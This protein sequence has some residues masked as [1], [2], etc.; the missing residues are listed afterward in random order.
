M[1]FLGFGSVLT[2]FP[3]RPVDLKETNTNGAGLTT[4]LVRF[5]GDVECVVAYAIKRV[6]VHKPS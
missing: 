6:P 1:V 2:T 3:G 5:S 4:V